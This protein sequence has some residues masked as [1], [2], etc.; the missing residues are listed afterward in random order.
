MPETP[1]PASE[2]QNG[3]PGRRALPGPR[4]PTSWSYPLCCLP[5]S[6]APS[7]DPPLFT[8]IISTRELSPE[9]ETTEHGHA[10]C[11]PIGPPAGA[12]PPGPRIAPTAQRWALTRHRHPLRGFAPRLPSLGLATD[13]RPI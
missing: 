9:R 2:S 7:P 10:P 12:P 6:S 11:P 3:I 4:P 8:A 5:T 13:A 1:V